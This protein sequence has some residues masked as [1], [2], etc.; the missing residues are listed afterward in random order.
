M[1]E[2]Q[3]LYLAEPQTFFTLLAPRPTLSEANQQF[4]ISSV[5]LE[6]N[7]NLIHKLISFEERC[8]RAKA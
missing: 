3:E 7:S 2:V 6:I 1:F 4:S 8:N 5:F